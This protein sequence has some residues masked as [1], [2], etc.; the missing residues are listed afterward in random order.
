MVSRKSALR[1]GLLALLVGALAA[2]GGS[3][4]D[5]PTPQ[6]YHVG[7]TVAGLASGAQLTVSDNAAGSLVIG[8]SGTFTFAAGL[9]SGS[10]YDVTVNANPAGQTCNVA[11]GSGVVQAANIANIVVTC[12]DQAFTLGGPVAGLSASGLML[13]NGSETVAVSAGATSFAFSQSLPYAS[14]Y[15]VSVV[16][17]PQGLACAVQGGSGVMPA[18]AVTSVAIQCT[19]QPFTLGGSVSGL[20]SASGLVLANGADTVS[21]A[22]Q[23]TT[24]AFADR[25]AFGSA[26]QVTVQSPPAGLECN[27]THGSGVMPAAAVTN[28]AVVCAN[29]IHAVGGSLA[30]LLASG[31]VLTNGTDTLSVPPRTGHFTMPTLIPTGATYSIAVQTQPQG[32][33]CTVS[34]GSGTMGSAD[35]TSVQI[36]CAAGVYTVGGSVSGLTAAGLVLANGSDTLSV[37]AGAAT[38]TMSQAEAPNSTYDITVQAHPVAVHCQ[39]ADGS[40]IVGNADVSSVGVSCG[41]GQESLLYSFSAANS[42]GFTP[43]GTLLQAWSTV[44]YGVTPFGGAQG[45]GTIYSVQPD[46]TVG[47]LYSFAGGTDGAAPYASLIQG[48]DGSLYGVTTAGGANGT[49]VVFR[50]NTSGVETV[51]YPFGTG[52]DA[53]QPYGSLLQ[54]SDGNFYGMSLAGGVNNQGTVF[55][56]TPTGTETVLHS[57]GSGTDGSAPHGALI[58]G[59]DGNLYGVTSQG[60]ENGHGILFRITL[61]GVETVLYA[62][63]NGT[64]ASDPRGSLIQASDGNFYGLSAH[65]G[66][67]GAGALF[68]MTSGGTESV[69][70]SFGGSGDGANPY[71]DPLQGSDGELYVLT[72]NGGAN[73]AGALVRVTLAGA[74]SVLYSFGGAGDGAAPYGSL[75]ETADGTLWGVTSVGGSSGGGTV[76]SID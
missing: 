41:A 52:S 18:H 69:L 56:V 54:G 39:V 64:D 44:L 51:L 71:G 9:P 38:F 15:A 48:A 55:R 17:Q 40:G 14:P 4:G 12:A 66:Q 37:L 32:L 60:G 24:F 27:V 5:A 11:G 53:Q 16:S 59:T 61:Q 25:V 28:V 73:G 30:G 50:I 31:L 47:V 58:Q 33:T 19:D 49:G 29:N 10:P 36:Q 20:G 74:E 34:D 7:G 2:C 76:F 42:G 62:F 75:I 8:Q 22:A 63:A 46:G 45:A 1:H 67:Y 57:F 65:G 3:G 70:V 43:Y 26:Y 6:M 13:K 23:A 21:V 35:V 72:L 68:K